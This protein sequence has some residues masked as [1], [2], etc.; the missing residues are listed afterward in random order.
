[1]KEQ[2]TAYE[3]RHFKVTDL[4]NE[5]NIK[6]ASR[7]KATPFL[8]LFKYFHS[9]KG[10]HNSSA[11]VSFL[12][13][14]YKIKMGK[15]MTHSSSTFRAM[16]RR[17]EI[18][19]TVLAALIG[20]MAG[21]VVAAMN[22]IAHWAHKLLFAVPGVG[23]LSAQ[24]YIEPWRI[25]VVPVL[26][27][28]MMGAFGLIIAR[29]WPG[30]QIDPVE[31][32]ALHGG[33][34]SIRDSLIV[35]IQT[36]IS[37]GAGA[38]IGL[39]SGFTQLSS[40]LGSRLGRMLRVRRADLRLL[41]G[42]GAAGGIGAAFNA[43][44]AG[45]FY[46]FELI[47][48][49]YALSSLP[50]VAMAS[51]CAILTTHF[52]HYASPP[53]FILAPSTVSWEA[54]LP[55][56]GLAGL[57]A[58]IGIVVMGLVTLVEKAFRA[59][60]IPHWG[61]QAVG[62][63]FVGAL[64]LITPAV[65]SSGHAALRLGLDGDFNFYQALL[66]LPLKIL[67]SSISIGSGFRGGLFFASLFI[68]MLTGIVYGHSLALVGI[69]PLSIIV[70]ALVG[71]SAMAVAVLG[72]PMTMVFLTL[73]MTG[74]L[75]L[76]VVVL[77][78]AV[79]SSLTVRRI[80]GYS[81]ATW[82][83][84]L[85]GETIRSAVDVSWLRL[86]TVGRMMRKEVRTFSHHQTIADAKSFFPLGSAPSFALVDNEH[87]YCGMVHVADLYL[88]GVDE[89]KRVD[90]LA[91]NE[92]VMLLPQM[93][94]KEAIALFDASESDLLVVVDNRDTMQVIGM[95]SEQHALKRYSEELDKT[96]RELSGD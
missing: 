24:S 3:N 69:Q 40:A 61:R 25:M 94:V 7:V 88:Q 85:R 43:P 55:L 66:I 51:I 91:H 74:S 13:K 67:A 6:A 57:S 53:I 46:A 62:G 31:A 56:M 64:G 28:I 11:P 63:V 50:P 21:G 86:L 4:K 49:T 87:H 39:E 52:L 36:L 34:M 38:S 96:R 89:N 70:Y 79:V 18:W 33:R 77:M 14:L 35:V 44:L 29:Y 92:D 59:S 17:D 32:N 45:A 12:S 58:L 84:H 72:G 8:S 16:V 5:E 71:M 15:W 23:M 54:Y 48:G 82:R 20:C 78:A 83:F 30:R 19:L 41:V 42:C 95:L 93:N 1:M 2:P 60:W 9:L 90:Y 81:F 37:N 22:L 76:S 68:G 10:V 26:G 80:F 73:E 27:G 65:L 75:P 47:I